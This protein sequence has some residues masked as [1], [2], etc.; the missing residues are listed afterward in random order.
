MV[1]VANRVFFSKYDLFYV[2]SDLCLISPK[3]TVPTQTDVSWEGKL[4]NNILVNSIYFPILVIVIT[5]L[6]ITNLFMIDSR[7]ISLMINIFLMI[8][9]RIISLMISKLLIIDSRIIS[10]MISNFFMINLRN[11]QP[12]NKHRSHMKFEKK[13]SNDDFVSFKIQP[14]A[15]VFSCYSEWYLSKTSTAAAVW[16]C[17][18][19]QSR[20]QWQT[21]SK[22]GIVLHKT[23]T[24]KLVYYLLERQIRCQLIYNI[25]TLNK[26]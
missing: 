22:A 15:L 6:M 23:K 26:R 9:S 18:T 3:K 8:V 16:Q 1:C 12:N 4:L 17:D 14:R 2:R 5:S 7:I 19:S 24:R 20:D 21:V 10:L 25:T 13:L 11:C